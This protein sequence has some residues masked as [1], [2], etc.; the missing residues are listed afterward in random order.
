MVSQRALHAGLGLTLCLFATALVV[1]GEEW[2]VAG[3]AVHCGSGSLAQPEA[4]SGCPRG[5]VAA[6]RGVPGGTEPTQ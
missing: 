6:A 5:P 1:Q 2:M 3:A 4:G